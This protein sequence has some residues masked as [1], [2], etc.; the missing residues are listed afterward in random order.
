[1]EVLEEQIVESVRNAE[2]GDPSGF[3]PPPK[4]RRGR[5]R[6]S[7]EVVEARL[8]A[9][10]AA[11]ENSVRIRQWKAAR[12]RC[13]G[14]FD[15]LSEVSESFRRHLGILE[16]LRYI[17]RASHGFKVTIHRRAYRFETSIIGLSPESLKRAITERD[18]ALARL[19]SQRAHDVPERVLR[20]LGLSQPIPGITRLPERSVYRLDYEE[21][22]QRHTRLFYYRHVLEEDA[23]AAAVELADQIFNAANGTGR[24][25]A[26]F[27]TERDEQVMANLEQ[28]LRAS[29]PD[30]PPVLRAR[31]VSEAPNLLQLPCSPAKDADVSRP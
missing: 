31:P 15:R 11:R 16:V 23:Y 17:R 30:L 6:L 29:D 3:Q 8:E 19:P 9:A 25:S 24:F 27:L 18:E 10:K 28:L 22:G 1:M 5:P 13:R 7:P 2:N 26:A 12:D 14:A 4:V 20:A 21:E